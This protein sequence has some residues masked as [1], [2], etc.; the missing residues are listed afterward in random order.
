MVDI[1]KEI[2]KPDP[3]STKVGVAMASNTALYSGDMGL[4]TQES[5]E[6]KSKG[7]DSMNLKSSTDNVKTE[8]KTGFFNRKK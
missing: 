3:L 5:A 7:S 6:P 1:L 2:H 4:L 8:K